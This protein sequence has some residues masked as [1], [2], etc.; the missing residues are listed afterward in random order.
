[1]RAVC[2]QHRPLI[3]GWLKD[4]ILVPKIRTLLHRHTGVLVPER[5]LMRFVTGE[6]D[7]CRKK[8]TTVRVADGELGKELQ[9]DFGDHQIGS[10]TTTLSMTLSVYPSIRQA[11]S[12]GVSASS[13]VR[14]GKKRCI[15]SS[16]SSRK[17]Y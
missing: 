2:R 10:R 14:R 7:R 1:M 5:T 4:G 13:T 12:K 15:G 16:G 17:P 6:I 8:K 3:E 9:I 11:G